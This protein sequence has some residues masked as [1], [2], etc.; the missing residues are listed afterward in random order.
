MQVV[1]EQVLTKSHRAGLGIPQTIKLWR[2]CR[3][4]YRA[5]MTDEQFTEAAKTATAG[6]FDWAVILQIVQAIFALL[7]KWKK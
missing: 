5:G 3:N 2:M 1:P 4:V 7:Q 6:A